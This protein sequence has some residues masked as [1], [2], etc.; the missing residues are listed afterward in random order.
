MT[1][2]QTFLSPYCPKDPY[3]CGQGLS[4]TALCPDQSQIAEPETSTFC[5]VHFENQLGVICAPFGALRCSISNILVVW[6]L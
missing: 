6:G 5:G 3:G 4:M 2:A 1:A